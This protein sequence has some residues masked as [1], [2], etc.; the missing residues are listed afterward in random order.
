MKKENTKVNENVEVEEIVEVQETEEVM[1]KKGI[2]TKIG[3]AMDKGVKKAAP[4]AKKVGKGAILI[5]AGAAAVIAGA[6][7]KGGKTTESND[8][9]EIEAEEF[10]TKYAIE[11]D[12]E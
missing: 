3:E 8:Y 11:D 6:K 1:P 4:V 2:F 5:G 9:D 10:D 7:L 12:A